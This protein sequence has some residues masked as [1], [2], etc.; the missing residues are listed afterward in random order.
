MDGVI[1]STIKMSIPHPLKDEVMKVLGWIADLCRDNPDCLGCHLYGDLLKK[2][3]LVLEQVWKAQEP[4]DRHLRSEEYRNLLIVLEMSR[5][6]PEI[7][8]DTITHSTGI[9]TIE[10]A[11]GCATEPVDI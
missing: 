2:D 4:L 3:V 11:R 1:Q 6:K 10:R 7:R 9:E 5:N 8:F